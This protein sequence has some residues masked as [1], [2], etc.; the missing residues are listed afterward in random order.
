MFRFKGNIIMPNMKTQSWYIQRMRTLWD[1]MLCTIVLTL[2]F[3]Y[4]YI[5]CLGVKVYA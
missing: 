5:Y 2:K 1:P 3:M 4:L